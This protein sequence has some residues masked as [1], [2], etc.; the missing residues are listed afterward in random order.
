MVRSAAV[1]SRGR[2]LLWSHGEECSC[3]FKG[4]GTAVLPLRGVQLCY[5]REAASWRPVKRTEPVISR[6]RDSL[7]IFEAKR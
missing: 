7:F 3:I 6:G 2:G 4:E 1:F 5:Q